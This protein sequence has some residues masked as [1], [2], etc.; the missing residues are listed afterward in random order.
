[1]KMPEKMPHSGFE[2]MPVDIVVVDG[3]RTGPSEILM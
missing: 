3:F 1:M 2:K